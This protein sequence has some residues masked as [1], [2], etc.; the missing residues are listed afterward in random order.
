MAVVCFCLN[1]FV[2][3]PLQLFLFFA[4]RWD[5]KRRNPGVPFTRAA[6]R[7]LFGRGAAGATESLPNTEPHQSRIC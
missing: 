3:L 6:L 1:L 7:T 2:C 5:Y 4:I